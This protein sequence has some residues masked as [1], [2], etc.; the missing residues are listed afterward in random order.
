MIKFPLRL[1]K[2]AEFLF[3]RGGEKYR[4]PFFLLE[5]RK[6]SLDTAPGQNGPARVG[7]TVT[8]KNGNAVVRNRIRRRLREAVRT[9]LAGYFAPGTDYVIVAHPGIISVPFDHLVQELKRYIIC[10]KKRKSLKWISF[11]G[12]QS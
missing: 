2:R 6:R 9:T 3:V 11:D 12:I 8:R 4:G 5:L 10:K 1:R 7:F